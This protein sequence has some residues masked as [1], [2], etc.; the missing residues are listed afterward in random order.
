MELERQLDQYEKHQTEILSR[1]SEKVIF[2]FIAA[3]DK[4]ILINRKVKHDYLQPGCYWSYQFFLFDPIIKP[5]LQFSL[6]LYL[7]LFV[8]VCSMRM[9]QDPYQ[10]QVYLLLTS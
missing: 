3:E 10:T 9:E 6:Y 4:I 2:F 7:F 8:V 5:G 1:S